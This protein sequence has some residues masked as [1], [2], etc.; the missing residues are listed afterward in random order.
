MGIAFVKESVYESFEL[1]SDI[2]G[3]KFKPRN[4]EINSLEI[5]DKRLIKK[6]LIKKLNKDI[7]KSTKAIKLMLK[8]DITE[9]ND[10]NIMITELKRI[11]TNI[12]NKYMRYFTELEYFE[13]IK[14][15][16]YLNMEINLKKSLLENK[17]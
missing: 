11:A 14:D 3:Y 1:N 6:V 13:L 16:Y 7:N 4:K 2:S 12:E 15:I 9:V 10:C 5:V 17:F 8:S